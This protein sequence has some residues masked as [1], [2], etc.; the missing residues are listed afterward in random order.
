MNLPEVICDMAKVD[1]LPGIEN[2]YHFFFDLSVTDVD[3]I[4]I[5]LSKGVSIDEIHEKTGIDNKLIEKIQYY[6]SAAQHQRIAPLAP[7]M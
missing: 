4:L 3:S 5:R 6:F 7:K 1:L 2:K